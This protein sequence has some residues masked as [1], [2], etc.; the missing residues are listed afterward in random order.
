MDLCFLWMT[1]GI[2]LVFLWV[3]TDRDTDP[4]PDEESEPADWSEW[5]DEGVVD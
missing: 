5:D 3:I 2:A 4:E 1:C